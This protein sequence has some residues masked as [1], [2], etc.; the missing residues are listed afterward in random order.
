M[1]SES[2]QKLQAVIEQEEKA[3]RFA[4]TKAKTPW[5]VMTESADGK[6]SYKF[7]EDHKARDY[8]VQFNQSKGLRLINPEH[9]D[10]AAKI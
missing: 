6:R 4:E 9:F 7:F 3:Y 1:E 2:L 5:G 8:W 10:I